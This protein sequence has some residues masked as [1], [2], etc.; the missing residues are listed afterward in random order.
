[1]FLEQAGK[2]MQK[3]KKNAKTKRMACIKPKKDTI[4]SSLIK[5]LAFRE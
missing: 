5:K 1:M 4:R 2:K 3:P